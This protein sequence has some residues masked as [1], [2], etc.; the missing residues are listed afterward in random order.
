MILQALR[1]VV[2]SQLRLLRRSCPHLLARLL[3]IRLG[4]KKVTI[5]CARIPTPQP[6]NGHLNHNCAVE[7]PRLMLRSRA[8]T[9]AYAVRWMENAI[10]ALA[11]LLALLKS[12]GYCIVRSFRGRK[13]R[14]DEP[15]S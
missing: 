3:L 1:C 14:S 7:V 12:S 10:L 6:I 8:L 5:A 9:S 15:L 2:G 11:T 13:S 4:K